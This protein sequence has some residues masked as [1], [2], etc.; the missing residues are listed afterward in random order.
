MAAQYFRLVMR[1]G[2]SPGKVFELTQGEYTIGRDINNVIVINDAEVSRNHVRLLSQAGGYVIEDLGSTNGTFVN[3]Q[4]LMGPHMLQHG[5]M[6][7][8]GDNISL[9]YEAPQFDQG[10]TMVSGSA[11][12]PHTPI[13][14]E[15]PRTMPAGPPASPYHPVQDSY[16]GSVPPGPAEPAYVSQQDYYTEPYEEQ[17]SSRTWI[18]VGAGCLV[19]ILCV[20]VAG[21]IVF[22]FLDLYCAGPFEQFF[23]CP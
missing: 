14:H 15:T 4:R 16:I 20:L 6:I 23:N 8:M 19:A 17:R 21:A 9:A 5:E 12:S 13:M 7:S 18:Y 11:V 1:A 10:A 3:G 2:P 22:D